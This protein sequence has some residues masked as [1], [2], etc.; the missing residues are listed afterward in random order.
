MGIVTLISIRLS[1]DMNFLAIRYQNVYTRTEK[2]FKL[3]DD[4]SSL[5]SLISPDPIAFIE[6]PTYWKIYSSI[7]LFLFLPYIFIFFKNLFLTTANYFSMHFVVY[8]LM[9]LN[10]AQ[11][12]TDLSVTAF[13]QGSASQVVLS[14]RRLEQVLDFAGSPQ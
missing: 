14:H 6:Q 5:E 2:I 11:V 1:V 13:G 3:G 7:L 8:I 9:F 12:F 4:C 10:T